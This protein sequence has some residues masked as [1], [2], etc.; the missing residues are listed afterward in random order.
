MFS[1]SAINSLDNSIRKRIG[2]SVSAR[3]TWD[4]EAIMAAETESKYK[5]IYDKVS[6]INIKVAQSPGWKPIL[7]SSTYNPSDGGTIVC[8][9]LEKEMAGK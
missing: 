3:V 5:F 9:V 6:G 4:L 8:L 2:P 1:L 7:I